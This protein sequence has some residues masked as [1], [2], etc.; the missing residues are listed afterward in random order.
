MDNLFLMALVSL[1]LGLTL[2]RLIQIDLATLR[3][4]DR[5][6]LPLIAAGLILN[7]IGLQ[8]VPWNHIAAAATGYLLFAIIGA[9]FYRLRGHEGLGL[10]DA[11]LLSAAGAWL[12]LAA[13][14]YVIMI[15]AVSGLVFALV[16]GRARRS[17]LVFGPWLASGFW[18]M[19]VAALWVRLP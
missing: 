19:W 6:T 7:A 15:A 9:L 2:A 3:L 13:L 18:F 1:G 5:Y 11:K 8:T 10:G 12:G 16:R 14:P 4:P 17:P